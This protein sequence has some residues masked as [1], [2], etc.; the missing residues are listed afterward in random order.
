MFSE[1]GSRTCA[2]SSSAP[3]SSIPETVPDSQSSQRVSQSPPFGAP[4]VPLYVPPPVP[5]FDAP[6][7]HHDHVPEEAPPPMAARIHPNLSVPPSAPYAIYTI[8]DILDQPGRE[9][10]PVLDPD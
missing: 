6:P 5:R 3:S 4:P 8:E 9:G 2:S 1:H 10:L 7:A